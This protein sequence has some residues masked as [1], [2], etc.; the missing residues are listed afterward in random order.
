MMIWIKA[1]KGKYG[2]E[3][4]VNSSDSTRLID[5]INGHKI[6]TCSEQF[7]ILMSNSESLFLMPKIYCR[8]P[9]LLLP[10]FVA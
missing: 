7:S 10:K 9:F 2:A 8:K 5:C 4:R 3:L 1:R 6:Q